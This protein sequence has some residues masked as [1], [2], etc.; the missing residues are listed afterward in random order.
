MFAPKNFRVGRHWKSISMMEGDGVIRCRQE[1]AIIDWRSRTQ[2]RTGADP[3][4]LSWEGGNLKNI[5][6]GRAKIIFWYIYT[7][8]KNLLEGPLPPGSLL[9]SAPD[10]EARCRQLDAN[11]D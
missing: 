11:W 4:S 2:P 3:G 7:L 8:K 5:F 10:H 6:F 1:A 9:R